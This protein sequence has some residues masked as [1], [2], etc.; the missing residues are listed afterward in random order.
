MEGGEGA[1]IKRGGWGG[2]KA[3]GETP[4]TGGGGGH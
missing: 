2:F 1:Q 4:K 3:M